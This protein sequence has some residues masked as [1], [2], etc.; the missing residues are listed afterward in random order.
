LQAEQETLPVAE[1]APL[2]QIGPSGESLPVTVPSL[3]EATAENPVRL[4]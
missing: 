4:E 1:S 3:P 2:T